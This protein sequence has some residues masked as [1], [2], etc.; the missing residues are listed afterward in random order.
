VLSKSVKRKIKKNAVGYMFMA[1][2]ILGLGI[3]T[4][5]PI[6]Q[7]LIYS[8]Y[9]YDGIMT[10]NYIGVKNYIDLFTS[11]S[12]F[13][14][15]IA[16]TAIFAPVNVVIS[17]I[18]TYLLALF[19]NKN[20]K[21]VMAFRLLY[22][23]PVVIPGVISGLMW[24]DIM[25]YPSGAFNTVLT[26][27]GLKPFA[28]FSAA[29][30]S[31]VSVFIMQLWGIGGGMILWLAA[32]KNIP[33]TFYE[34]ASL[35]GAGKFKQLIAITLPMSTPTIFYNVITGIIGALQFNGTLVFA[36]RGGTGIKNSIFFITVKIYKDAF[37][38]MNF[39]YASATA[40][41]L[42]AVIGLL[43]ILLFKTSKWVFYGDE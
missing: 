18:F 22:Y 28:F 32:F 19:V 34:S 11:D 8:F 17:I 9:K 7:S 29:N 27:F 15:V 5:W 42:F 20:V 12:D 38:H 37:E 33:R 40:W 25:K 36:P 41:I 39:G 13:Y 35:D 23:M 30:T 2:L 21:G 43:V 26:A 6:I 10:F 3:F 14:K 1:P 31:M 4:I 24:V 16:N